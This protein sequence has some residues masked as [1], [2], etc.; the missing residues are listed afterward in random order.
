MVKIQSK[1]GKTISL[2]SSQGSLLLFPEGKVK[3]S[4]STRVLLDA[5]DDS[6]NGNTVSW[7]GEYD[8]GGVSIRGIGQKEGTQISYVVTTESI[9]CGFLSSP[10]GEWSEA[11]MQIL[12]DLDVLVVPADDVKL[13]QKIVE[14]VDPPVIIPLKS[15]DEKI[16]K[17]VVAACGGKDVETVKEVKL[18]KSTLPTE[19]REVYVLS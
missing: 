14:E 18:K 5:P 11:D 13:V 16:F 1:G 4:D 19:S 3:A 7:P 2:E 6:A 10:V 8:Y 12:G 17:E 9:R 15:K